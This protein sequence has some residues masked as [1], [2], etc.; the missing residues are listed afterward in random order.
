MITFWPA[1][2]GQVQPIPVA[3]FAVIPVG[4]VIVAVVPAVLAAVPTLLATT[5]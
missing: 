3:V 4:R 5:E 1:G 2:L